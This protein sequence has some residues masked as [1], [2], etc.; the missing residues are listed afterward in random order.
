MENL[1]LD[2][3]GADGG[4][5]VGELGSGVA[6]GGLEGSN[7]RSDGGEGV[8]G[9]MEG[10]KLGEEVGVAGENL[11]VER[12]KDIGCRGKKGGRG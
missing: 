7:R 2:G 9:V 3:E 12:R 6:K 11:R 10:R 4:K 8:I 5:G 1:E